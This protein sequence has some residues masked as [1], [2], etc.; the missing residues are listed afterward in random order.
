MNIDIL[1]EE[2]G[3]SIITGCGGNFVSLGVDE[4]GW[5]SGV[6]LIGAEGANVISVLAIMSLVELA[7]MTCWSF[8]HERD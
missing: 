7:T 4:M 3:V 1:W 8:T 6:R 2:R 5:F